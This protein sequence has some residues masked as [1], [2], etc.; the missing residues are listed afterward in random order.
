MS[1]LDGKLDELCVNALSGL[2]LISTSEYQKLRSLQKVCKCPLG[3]KPHFYMKSTA[4]Y[5]KPYMGVNALSGLYLIST[6]N[7]KTMKEDVYNV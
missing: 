6:E 7:V 2:Y 5:I 1:E 4:K 3:L